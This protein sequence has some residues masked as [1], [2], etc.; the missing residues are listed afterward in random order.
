MVIAIVVSESRLSNGH[1]GSPIVAITLRVM[2]SSFANSRHHSAIA[3]I[4]RSMMATNK[5]A[6]ARIE[7]NPKFASPFVYAKHQLP[8]RF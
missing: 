2:K 3:I 4:M 8:A 5:I 1:A 7:V 6:H